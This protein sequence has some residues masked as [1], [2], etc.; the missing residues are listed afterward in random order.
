MKVLLIAG[1]GTLGVY[2]SQELL[3]LGYDVDVIALEAPE[4]DDPRLRYIRTR[5]DDAFL[6]VHLAENRYDAIVD[7]I[8]Y[9]DPELYRPRCRLLLDSTE[10]LIFLSSYRVYADCVHPIR[11]TSPKLLE[12]CRDD[13]FLQAHDTY[14]LSKSRD[15]AVLRDTGRKNWTVVR[16]LISF[17][18]YR[19][20]LVTQGAGT[21]LVR[22]PQRKPILLPA[23]S[24]ALT[25][26]LTWAGNTGKMIAHLV[27]CEAALGEAYTLGAGESFTW[28]EAAG[29]YT[30][31]MGAE[32]VWVDTETYLR[33]ATREQPHDRVILC[34]DRL[35]DR[36]VD[37]AK[38]LAATG[39]TAADFT[40]VRDALA[41]ELRY[42]ADHPDE[43]LQRILNSEGAAL[44]NRRMDEYLQK[45]R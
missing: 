27:H 31:L 25:A 33:Y 23:D 20:D 38:I 35:Y 3:R 28:R 11:E 6:A 22:P 18:H 12:V 44:I 40:P 1:G 2:T 10:Q 42:A 45:N 43:R 30:D 9:P 5:A 17:S 14:G 41:Y 29:Y 21:L 26:G 4:S 19:F 15:E 39:L 36:A 24:A 32:F 7:F 37:N 13:A 34:Y 8:H 16:P